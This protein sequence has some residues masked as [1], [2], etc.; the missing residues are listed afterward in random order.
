MPIEPPATPMTARDDRC[1]RLVEELAAILG[2]RRL[3]TAPGAMQRY[4]RGYRHGGG[5]ALAVAIPA[6]LA[7][8]W[9]IVSVCVQK[10]AAIIVQAANT[11]LT[12]G[13]TP[14][15][16]CYD[17]P[18]VIISTL[19]LRTIRLLAG[20]RQVLCHAGATLHRLEALLAP[21]GRE[22][23]S[24]I[25]SSCIGASVV[26]GVCNNSG[27]ALIQ[28][29][30]AYTDYALFA[31]IRAGGTVELVNHLGIDLGS[32]DPS[33]MLDRLERWDGLDEPAS[34]PGRSASDTEYMA[35]VRQIDAPTPARFNSDP[36]RLRDTAG[37]AGKLVVFAVRLDTFPKPRQT[38]VFY[39]GTNRPDELT[40]LR[41]AVLDGFAELPIAAEYMHR[42]AFDIADRYGRDI[43]HAIRILG[44][45]RLSWL[46][47]LKD[48]IARLGRRLGL[49]HG[50]EERVMQHAARL[51]PNQLP[52]RLRRWRERYEHHLLVRCA[53]ASAGELHDWLSSHFPTA[54]GDWFA[55]SDKEGEAA[56]L[57]RFVAA[58]AAIRYRAVHRHEVEGLVALD[59][60]LRRDER[61]WFE[62]LPPELDTQIVDRLYYGH[63]FC[64]VFHHDYLVAKGRDSER[65]EHAMLEL[66][67]ARGAEY[68]AEHNVG[69]LYRAKDTL[70]SFYRSLDPT[71]TLNPGIGKL[72]KNKDYG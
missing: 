48:R 29:G 70:A 8:L 1:R 46:Y 44:T 57:H 24:V 53:G 36:R 27:G 56:F 45:E 55:C 52:A 16:D 63:F 60:A 58:G 43:F 28:R 14:D 68:P 30:P 62:T 51:M 32:G 6:S 23:H 7:E 20:G 50:F 13:S 34:V 35:W 42:S 21:L 66:L 5:P 71:N 4:T 37:C 18:L 19:K 41:R 9:R 67:D 12:S 54:S 59:I 49:G 69:H 61:H 25:G 33:E 65:L 47:A 2:R 11:G 3:F 72:S 10:D 31:R 40:A 38:R 39:I 15:G 26:G 22:P 64:H 17:R